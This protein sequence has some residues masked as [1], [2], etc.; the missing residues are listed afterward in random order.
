MPYPEYSS[1]SGTPTQS[2]NYSTGENGCK[3]VN[4][5][6]TSVTITEVA[7]RK[8]SG[9]TQVHTMRV[10]NSANP[11]VLLQSVDVDM[12]G[13]TNNTDI[14]GVLPSPI[15]LA[16]GD[17][18]FV[19]STEIAGSET[20]WGTTGFVNDYED[21]GTIYPASRNHSG[22]FS[23]DTSRWGK[24][25][26]P[27]NFRYTVPVRTWT[28]DPETMEYTTDGSTYQVKS[29]LADAADHPGSIVYFPGGHTTVGAAGTR[30]VVPVGVT[31]SGDP[32]VPTILDMAVDSPGGAGDYTTALIWLNS[33]ATVRSLTINGPDAVNKI[34]IRTVNYANDW[35]VIDVNYNQ[36]LTRNSYFVM[37]NYA[38]RGLI[39]RCSIVGGAGNSELIYGRGPDDAWNVPH[40]MGT[41][42][43]VFIEDCTY[44]GQG[45]IC[46][47][48]ANARFVV[49]HC[50]AISNSKADGHG[51]WTNTPAR[52]VRHMEIYNNTW[53]N[54]GNGPAI[55]LRGG[56]GR[57]FNNTSTVA[58]GATATHLLLTEY[59][60]TNSTHG[61]FPDYQT[62]AD[63]PIRDQI[64]R[65]KYST[66]NDWTTATSEPVYLWGNRKG[67]LPWAL[68]ANTAIPAAAQTRYAAQGGTP[69]FAWT[70]IIQPDRDYFIEDAAFTGASGVGIGTRDTME[71]LTPTKT[72]VGFWITAEDA[73]Y[74]WDGDSWVLDYEPYTYPHPRLAETDTPILVS[75][76]IDNTTLTLD[77]STSCT[78]GAG[79]NGGVT[80]TAAGGALAPTYDSGSGSARYYYTLSRTPA[81]G[82]VIS[83]SY[84]QP[85]DG[86]ESTLDQ[87]D[88][89][90][91]SL[92]PVTNNSTG[93][94]TQAHCIRTPG[95]YGGGF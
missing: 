70:D 10:Y 59:G 18:V 43:N 57:V 28:Y 94:S 76:T 7:R 21:I 54:T 12:A 95:A 17:W 74:I 24:A 93:N 80:L 32:D 52:G 39:A 44:N 48:N 27:V 50:T 64:G 11:P 41:A 53:Q 89:A 62:P 38:T 46:D 49:R 75:A 4:E 20:Y 73:F 15:V 31:L 72:G 88:L 85:G 6:G 81:S 35:A 77:W 71:G 86:I 33:S 55:E 63:Y 9:N 58:S 26:V 60:V 67:G 90:S 79:G 34:A 2:I 8:K 25:Y 1:W 40:T 19:V 56:G 16:A 5:S 61:N 37:V 14:W 36:Y 47:G 68:S 30:I 78:T 91:F 51:V 84:V 87:T 13:G 29:A 83:V 82:E 45:Y 23:V 66:L 42:D 65:G 69:P 92:Q 22:A 3:F